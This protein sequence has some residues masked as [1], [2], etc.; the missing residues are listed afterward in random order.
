MVWVGINGIYNLSKVSSFLSF[1]KL[2]CSASCSTHRGPSKP[3]NLWLNQ[4]ASTLP[5][6]HSVGPKQGWQTPP[7]SMTMASQLR[8]FL[9]FLLQRIKKPPWSQ[10][11]FLRW[12][13]QWVPGASKLPPTQE[14]FVI[15]PR[16]M[17]QQNQI[18]H[19]KGWST[20]S[21]RGLLKN[22][23]ETL[24]TEICLPC[25]TSANRFLGLVAA[26]PFMFCGQGHTYLAWRLRWNFNYECPCV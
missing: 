16:I 10:I 9:L 5:R 21:S 24:I 13:S 6:V 11:I 23:G 19:I 17:L 12:L 1:A 8:V 4:K 14:A 22:E 20:L 25:S 18:S 26:L 2:H 15:S 7:C 3:R